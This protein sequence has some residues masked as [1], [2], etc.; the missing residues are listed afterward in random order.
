M[1]ALLALAAAV[2]TAT[3]YYD[4]ALARLDLMPSG[5]YAE[6]AMHQVKP[7]MSLTEEVRERREDRASWNLITQVDRWPRKRVG[8]VDI[9]RHYL[10]PDAF[11][12]LV[13]PTVRRQ[14]SGVLPDLGRDAGVATTAASAQPL[15]YDVRLIG[16]E[17]LDGCGYAAHL[18]LD[19]IGDAET[20]NVREIWVRAGDGTLCRAIYRSYLFEL[21]GASAK[22]RTIVDARV[23]DLGLITSWRSRYTLGRSTLPLD[24]TFSAVAWSAEQPAYY[25]DQHLWDAHQRGISPRP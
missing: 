15:H 4:R 17:Q 2:S 1:I 11:L 13:T 7:G 3:G 20:Y 19:P 25:F 23:N 12:P 8:E 18:G 9:G 6:Y 10:I 5:P 16:L 14:A 21:Q 24:G 22:I